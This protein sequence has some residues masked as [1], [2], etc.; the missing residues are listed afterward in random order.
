[1]LAVILTDD[2]DDVSQVRSGGCCGYGVLGH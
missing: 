1:M 2:D